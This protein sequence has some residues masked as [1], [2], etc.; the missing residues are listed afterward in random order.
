MDHSLIETFLGVLLPMTDREASVHLAWRRIVK[1]TSILGQALSRPSHASCQ[2]GSTFWNS[3]FCF[4][5]FCTSW[6]PVGLRKSSPDTS[7]RRGFFV[8]DFQ[9]GPMYPILK[10]NPQKWEFQFENRYPQ[11]FLANAGKHFIP[12]LANMPL[13]LPS[14][15]PPTLPLPSFLPLFKKYNSIATF[16]PTSS[17]IKTTSTIVTHILAICIFC[18]WFLYVSGMYSYNFNNPIINRTKVE[19]N[20]SH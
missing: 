5:S 9:G 19:K 8:E 13:S 17:I 14:S 15:L 3:P 10:L 7:E 1:T 6:D 4:Y 11:T 2:Q 16:K 12:E 20:H 18:K